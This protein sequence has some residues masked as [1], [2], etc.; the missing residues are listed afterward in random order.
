MWL[1]DRLVYRRPT[2]R[3]EFTNA[4]TCLRDDLCMQAGRLQA[5]LLHQVNG[6]QCQSAG[7]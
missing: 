2:C 4:I 7:Q 5:A 3:S 6:Y 1:S